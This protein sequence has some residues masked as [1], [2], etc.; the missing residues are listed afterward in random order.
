ME[1]RRRARREEVIYLQRGKAEL[2]DMPKD[3]KGQGALSKFTTESLNPKLLY[4]STSF[5]QFYS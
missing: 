5:P 2:G 1:Q 3:R 4:T